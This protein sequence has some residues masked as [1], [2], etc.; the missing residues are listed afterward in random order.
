L[1]IAVLAGQ[2]A[3]AMGVH[4]N[5]WRWETG[6]SRFG[7]HGEKRGGPRGAYRGGRPPIACLRVRIADY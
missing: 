5:V 1:L 7:A 2:A 4:G 3:T 6:A